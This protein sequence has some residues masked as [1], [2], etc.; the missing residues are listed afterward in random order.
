MPTIT[1]ESGIENLSLLEELNLSMLFDDNI[2]PKKH[3]PLVWKVGNKIVTIGQIED[4]YKLAMMRKEQFEEKMIARSER[5]TLE[6]GKNVTRIP[7]V[8]DK[9]IGLS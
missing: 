9:I 4:L 5:K 7:T 2:K 6:L 8:E 3:H 1:N